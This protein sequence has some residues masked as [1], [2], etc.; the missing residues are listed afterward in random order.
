MYCLQGRESQSTCTIFI[1]IYDI[2]LEKSIFRRYITVTQMKIAL[3]LKGLNLII[4][5]VLKNTDEINV[6]TRDGAF[7]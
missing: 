3:I 7:Y 4:M 6:A 2:S 1:Y 5:R